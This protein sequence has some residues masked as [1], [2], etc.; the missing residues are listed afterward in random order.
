LGGF[1]T[2]G[3]NLTKIES[4]MSGGSAQ[5]AQFYVDCEAHLD[6]KNMQQAL[7]ELK[8]YCMPDGVRVLGCYPASPYRY[9]S[10][11]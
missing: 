9:L 7:E 1:A 8:F 6:D 3:I 5:D 2:N 10:S 4:Y 11:K